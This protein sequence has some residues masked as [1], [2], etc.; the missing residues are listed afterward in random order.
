[1]DRVDPS[2]SDG[3]RAESWGQQEEARVETSIWW[4]RIKSPKPSPADS[5]SALPQARGGNARRWAANANSVVG[6]N[7]TKAR[8]VS[9]LEEVNT[10]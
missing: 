3:Q 2:L 5:T 6:G 10:M 1:M 9:P 7:S 4:L 8:S